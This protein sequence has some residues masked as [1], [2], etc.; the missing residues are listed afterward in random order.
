MTWVKGQSGNPNGRVPLAPELAPTIR[1]ELRRRD[2]A[3]G[4]VNKRA[5]ALVLI[6][7]AV[8]GDL[9]AVRIVLE[10]VD[11]KVPTPVEHSGAGGGPIGLAFD[12]GLAVADLAA[13]VL[14]GGP[15][16]DRLPPGEAEVRGDGAPV[17]EDP[18][19]R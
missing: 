2:P 18:D 3:T 16:R 6:A 4:L 10:R 17:G 5:I 14:A 7:K 19:G 1:R 8:A 12:Y 15:G 9:E 13:A 11:G